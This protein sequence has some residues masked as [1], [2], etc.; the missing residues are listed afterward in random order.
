MTMPNQPRA[1][2]RHV[3]GRLVLDD[4]DAVA[5]FRAI[6]KIDCRK[7]VRS[8]ADRVEHFVRRIAERGADPAEWIVVIINVD[9]PIGSQLADAFMP[10]QDWSEMRARGEIP[11]ARGL[12][13]RGGLQE[14]LDASSDPDEGAKLRA[15]SGVAIFVVDHGVMA[16]FSAAEVARE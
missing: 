7:T 9:D 15:I 13:G 5:L 10:G 4:P 3:G 2:V 1:T 8:Q 14:I 16:V 6:G 12:A 11:F